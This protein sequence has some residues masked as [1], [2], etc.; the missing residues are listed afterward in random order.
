MAKDQTKSVLIFL[1]LTTVLGTALY[2]TVDNA[3]NRTLFELMK[4]E[5]YS[6]QSDQNYTVESVSRETVAGVSITEVKANSQDRK[7]ETQIFSDVDQEFAENYISGRKKELIS[8]YTDTPAPY[9]GIPE[10]EVDCPERFIPDIEDNS[11]SHKYN[12]QVYADEDMNTGVCSNSTADF[13]VQISI[14]YCQEPEKIVETK[15][16]TPLDPESF[17]RVTCE[18]Q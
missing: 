5:G 16:F 12:Y 1:A 4:S 13:K 3:E 7:T 17:Y 15:Q 8:T 9:E 11:S 6:L 14:I 10:K 2:T 18:S